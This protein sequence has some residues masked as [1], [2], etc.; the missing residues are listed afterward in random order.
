ME[1]AFDVGDRARAELADL[2]DRQMRPLG[3]AVLARLH[4]ADGQ[5]VMD[6]GCGAGEATIQLAGLVG[7]TVGS[8]VSTSPR[9]SSRSP[10]VG[11]ATWPM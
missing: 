4:V 9:A 2:I 11:R 3:D 1:N 7:P 10:D 8:S 5:T 6:V